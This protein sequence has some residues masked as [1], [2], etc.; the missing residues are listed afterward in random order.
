MF[1]RRF[2]LE[3]LERVGI[4]TRSGAAILGWR[5]FLALF[6]QECLSHE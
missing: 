4:A 2:V 5:V 6:L 3:G 1:F